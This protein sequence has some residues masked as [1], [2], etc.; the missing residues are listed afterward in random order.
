MP[1]VDISINSFQGG[2][3]NPILFG[4]TESE[5]F[6]RSCQKLENMFVHVEGAAEKRG[7]TKF[8]APARDETN[9]IR[10]IEFEFSREDAFMLEFGHLYIRV[11]ANDGIVQDSMN[12]DVVLTT[13]Y[14]GA[15]LEQIQFV[16]SAD[17]IFLAHPDHPPQQ[18][19][20][21]LDSSNNVTWTIEAYEFDDGPYLDENTEEDNK[22]S[23]SATSV[24]TGRT[25]TASGT[26]FEPFASTDVGRFVRVFGGTMWGYAKIT[27][28]VSSTSVTV[29]VLEAFETTAAQDRWQLGAWTSALGYPSAVTI[30]ERRLV[31]ANTRNNPQT[32]WGTITDDFYKFT[33]TETDGTVSADNGLSLTLGGSRVSLIRWVVG[34]QNLVIGTSGGLYRTNTTNGAPLSASTARVLYDNGVECA[35][36]QPV[37][38]GTNVIFLQKQRKKFFSVRYDFG[39]DGLSDNNISQYSE[40]LLREQITE[41]AIQKEPNSLFWAVREDG[42]LAC[43]TYE[44][45]QNVIA[46][47][48]HTISGTFRGRNARVESLRTVAGDGEDNVWMCVRRTINGVERRY[49]ERIVEDNNTD[50]LF[51]WHLDCAS[52]EDQ[53]ATVSNLTKAGD[54]VTITTAAAHGFS[55]NDQIAFYD[56]IGSD[57]LNLQRATITAVPTTT[58]LQF[59]FTETLG[60]Y[61]EGGVV[62]RF[63][64]TVTGLTHLEGETLT[65]LADGAA[66][67]D[68]TVSSGSIT[69]SAPAA[70]LIIGY[71]FSAILSP[72]HYVADGSGFGAQSQNRKKR[73]V[74][75][76]VRL[77]RTL[78]LKFGTS[79]ENFNEFENLDILPFRTT[80]DRMDTAIP[81][82]SGEVE[83]TVPSNYAFNEQF[84]LVNDQPFPFVILGI[85]AQLDVTR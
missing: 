77:H 15:Q 14:T 1:S 73:N 20:R 53:A 85:Y 45:A 63:F 57:E 18:F 62:R 11:L 38:I 47:G 65:V 44:P 7:G 30:Y 21:S 22:L 4:R 33:P 72:R 50:Q 41:Y 13:I 74:K 42:R 37:Q 84:F 68:V 43:C 2:E 70:V 40:H 29:E 82:M 59:N 3:L 61:I 67:P 76:F 79:L 19:V 60:T 5:F 6:R 46:W 64:E 80:S 83:F 48:L 54:V 24:G 51:A 25:I 28:F 27:A 17:V 75:T 23:I 36:I 12:N 58:S 35:D 81:L 66:Q 71:K 55:V 34:A 9:P 26:G 31:W 10:L 56:F 32:I 39:I 16:Q 49:I 52:Q 69:L 8:I 78:G